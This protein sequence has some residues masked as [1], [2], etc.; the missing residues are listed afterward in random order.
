M[1]DDKNILPLAA[2]P[3]GAAL[4]LRVRICAPSTW[5]EWDLAGDVWL[6]QS[7]FSA[8]P[9]DACVQLPAGARP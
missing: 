4:G 1:I 7:E 5:G 6:D 3:D 9:R 2:V 8:A